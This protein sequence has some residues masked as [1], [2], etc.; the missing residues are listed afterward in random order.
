MASARLYPKLLDL[1]RKWPECSKT[2]EKTLGNVL[3]ALVAKH[4]PE[5]SVSTSVTH[6]IESKVVAPS[7]EAFNNLTNNVHLKKYP[8]KFP[9]TSATGI[10]HEDVKECTIIDVLD[11]IRYR[12]DTVGT[13]RSVRDKL[14]KL[15]PATERRSKR[16][17]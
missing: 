16:S 17:D 7:Y 15:L 13:V 8:R 5:G 10:K 2:S 12:A 11:M 14:A 3:R 1:V 6:E 9:D 4:Y